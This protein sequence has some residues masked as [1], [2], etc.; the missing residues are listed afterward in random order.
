M[1]KK[2]SAAICEAEQKTDLLCLIEEITGAVKKAGSL[3]QVLNGAG[4]NTRLLA[5]ELNCTELQSILFGLAFNLNFSASIINVNDLAGFIGCEPITIARNVRDLEELV[6]LGLLRKD[7]GERRRY[8]FGKNNHT[9]YYIPPDIIGAI[10]EG[11]RIRKKKIRFDS[12]G[13][14]LSVTGELFDTYHNNEI[15]LEDLKDEMNVLIRNN[16]RLP[17]SK[18]LV[19]ARIEAESML[20]IMMISQ[21]MCNGNDE[22]KLEE[23]IGTLFHDQWTQFNQKQKFRREEHELLKKEM[24]C[25]V[26]S[27]LRSEFVIKL[28]EKFAAKLFEGDSDLMGPAREQRN[29]ELILHQV[30]PEKPLFYSG[31]EARNLQFIEEALMHENFKK[32]TKRLKDKG[33]CQGVSILLYGPPGTGKTESVYQ[34]ARR[35]GRDIR[36]IDISETKSY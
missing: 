3:A 11:T 24:V 1:K 19:K 34:L 10:C 26:A 32:L 13:E 27:S 5:H 36:Q 4:A 7:N 18:V 8:R 35:T 15:N 31:E 20:M 22:I 33:L 2:E 21:V 17:Y 16:I 23:L 25:F 30:I 14:L 28:T 6:R 29:A 9:S 12:L